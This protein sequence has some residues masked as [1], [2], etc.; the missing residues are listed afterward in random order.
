MKKLSTLLALAISLIACKKEMGLASKVT[1]DLDKF[2][3]NIKDTYGPQS[4]GF[5]Y[6]IGVGNTIQ[7]HGAM[8]KA[9][10]AADGAKNYTSETRQEIFSVT[11]FFTALAVVKALTNKGKTL[12]E[13]IVNYLPSTW[14]VHSDYDDLTFRKLLG[15]QSGFQM[16]NRTYDSLKFMMTLAQ[17]NT[18]RSYNNANFALC[19]ILLPYIVKGNAFF[20]QS[21][22][23]D[24]ILEQSTAEIFREQVRLLVLKPAGL[25]FWDKVD[26]KDW[27]HQNIADYPHTRYYLWS[28]QTLSS[29]SNSEDLLIAAGSRGL[30]LSTYEVVQTMIAFE[31]DEIVSANMVNTMKTEG[32]GFDSVNGIVGEQ[33]RYHWKNG[34]GEDRRGV[35]G[36]SIIMIFPKNNIT[37][38]INCNSNRFADDQFVSSASLLAKAYDDAW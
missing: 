26:F 13:P 30:T 2:E 31:E 4:V 9:R 12:D 37:V 34:A 33:G 24:N 10:L 29:T 23:D 17:G 14:T 8:G 20:S 18:S 28:D 5:S 38:S 25:T 15:H 22:S 21:E 32:L 7:R 16:S 27:H 6:A 11:K 1:F 19:R 36:E 3:Q 35:G